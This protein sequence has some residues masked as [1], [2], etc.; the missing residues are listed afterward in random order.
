MALSQE[1][2]GQG[3]NPEFLLC[4]A[5]DERNVPGGFLR[6][7]PVYGEDAGYTLDLMRHD[8]R[9]PNGMTEFLVARTAIALKERGIVRLSLNFAA[10]GRL[11]ADDV[12]RTVGQQAARFFVGLLNPFFQVETLR[13]FNAK[14]R[15]E[16][17]ARALV[18]RRPID[19]PR[20]GIRYIG[21]EG[22]LSIPGL[23]PLLVPRSVGGVGAPSVM[24]PAAPSSPAAPD[25]VGAGSS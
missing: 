9:A 17:L 5:F 22:L 12:Q 4:I 23:G 1:V 20:V 25:A 16:W 2:T 18:F 15:P 24:P 3:K 13:R 6:L 7:V 19:L 8:P 21:A 11:L 14:F 10:F